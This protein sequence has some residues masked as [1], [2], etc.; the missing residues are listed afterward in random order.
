M[1]LDHNLTNLLTV[2]GNNRQQNQ[3]KL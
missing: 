1:S 3:I 2:I